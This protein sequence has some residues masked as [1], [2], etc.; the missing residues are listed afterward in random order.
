[1]PSRLRSV[2]KSVFVASARRVRRPLSRLRSR[3]VAI[4]GPA[5]IA[6]QEAI[7]VTCEAPD[8]TYL[9]VDH[10]R[11]MPAVEPKAATLTSLKVAIRD[12]GAWVAQF[13][14][15]TPSAIVVGPARRPEHA[16]ATSCHGAG[17]RLSRHQAPK[18]RHGRQVVDELHGRGIIIKCPSNGGVA[19]EAPGAYKDSTAVV[20]AAHLAGL[21]RKV[22]TLE[23][24]I[25]IKG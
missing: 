6:L 24:H 13:V 18:Q 14:R 4:T 1:M 16:F 5:R 11:H 8:D 10:A 9:P 22:A 12:D 7:E 17:T 19:E 23:P 25:C 2:P 3:L 20:E 15:S 21:S